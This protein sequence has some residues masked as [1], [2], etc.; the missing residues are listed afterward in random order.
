MTI[1]ENT[2]HRRYRV[3]ECYGEI[4][5]SGVVTP[6]IDEYWIYRLIPWRIGRSMYQQLASNTIGIRKGV[7]TMIPGETILP[8]S[9]N[10]SVIFTISNRT[11]SDPID[12][13][14]VIRMELPDSM[15]VD[16]RSIAR[17]FI[18]DMNDNFVAPACTNR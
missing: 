7:M 4:A 16:G 2:I 5:K 3:V 13:I 14:G 11:L 18:G 1:Y 10:I 8:R 9:E 15:P 12:T 6:V 17:D